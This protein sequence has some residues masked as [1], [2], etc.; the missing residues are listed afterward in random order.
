MGKPKYYEPNRPAKQFN[1]T[2]K[3]DK[4]PYQAPLEETKEEKIPQ[5]FNSKKTVD[6][7]LKKTAPEFKPTTQT[8][9]DDDDFIITEDKFEESGPSENSNTTNQMPDF[10]EPTKQK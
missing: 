8:I 4:E 1:H 9:V 5:F 2:Y 7:K 3:V 10:E 6:T